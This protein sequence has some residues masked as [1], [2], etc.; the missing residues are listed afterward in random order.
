MIF[1]LKIGGNLELRIDDVISGFRYADG[2]W[3]RRNLG[4]TDTSPDAFQ[5]TADGGL[6]HISNYE[7]LHE[8]GGPKQQGEKF[9]R[10]FTENSWEL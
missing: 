10:N 3:L 1:T 5:P 7:V 8:F 6:W 2:L 9:H 4:D